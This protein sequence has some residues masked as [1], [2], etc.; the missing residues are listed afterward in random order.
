MFR[1][2]WK[3]NYEINFLSVIVKGFCLL[4]GA[5]ILWNTSKWLLLKVDIRTFAQNLLRISANTVKHA[6]SHTC[7]FDCNIANIN[8]NI[9]NIMYF[10]FYRK[11]PM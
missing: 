7:E 2:V 4:L 9:A 1:K 6:A 5:T 3:L 10:I 11:K 8:C